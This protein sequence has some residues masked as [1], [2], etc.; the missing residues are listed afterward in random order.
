MCRLEVD[1]PVQTGQE[2]GKEKEIAVADEAV[3]H[4]TPHHPF[5]AKEKIRMDI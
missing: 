4:C 5:I 3:V 2:V 1:S